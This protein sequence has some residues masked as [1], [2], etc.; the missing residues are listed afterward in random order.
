MY[1]RL[2]DECDLHVAL[3]GLEPLPVMVDFAKAYGWQPSDCGLLSIGQLVSGS[4]LLSTLPVPGTP[5]Q[6]LINP[7]GEVVDGHLGEFGDGERVRWIGL[8]RQ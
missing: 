8:I 3:V 5:T 4:K 2:S 7:T 1:R 6:Y